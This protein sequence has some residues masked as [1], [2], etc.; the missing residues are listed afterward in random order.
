MKAFYMSF[1]DMEPSCC[2][3]RVLGWSDLDMFATFKY[4]P[5]LDYFSCNRIAGS[6]FFKNRFKLHIAFINSSNLL[7]EVPREH[8]GSYCC[9]HSHLNSLED[10]E[11]NA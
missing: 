2:R 9:V 3:L 11:Y 1:E 6:F 8:S 4:P 10:N 7:L 5:L